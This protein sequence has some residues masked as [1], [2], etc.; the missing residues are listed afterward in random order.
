MI[1]WRSLYSN[2][3]VHGI[4]KEAIAHDLFAMVSWV[5][6]I[7]SH[8]THLLNGK[9]HNN[10]RSVKWIRCI[11]DANGS[12]VATVEFSKSCIRNM[13]TFLLNINPDAS[14]NADRP[15]L[16]TLALVLVGI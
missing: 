2:K 1:S 16:L 12:D 10:K 14:A 8:V 7:F 3:W 4:S 11:L 13:K 15:I 6:L 9:K 5:S